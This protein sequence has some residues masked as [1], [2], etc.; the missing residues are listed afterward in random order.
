M[1][2]GFAPGPLFGEILKAL[3][4][5]VIEAPERNEREYLLAR[6]REI[7]GGRSSS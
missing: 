1:A 5:E 6:A 4:D 3:L 2:A 7:A